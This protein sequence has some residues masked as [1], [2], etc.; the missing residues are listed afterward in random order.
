MIAQNHH[1][2]EHCKSGLIVEV[3]QELF[4]KRII[5]IKESDKDPVK[6]VNA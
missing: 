3:Q 1:F 4:F 2:P 6:R 5:Q